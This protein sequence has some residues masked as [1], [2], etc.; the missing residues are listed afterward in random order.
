MAIGVGQHDMSFAQAGEVYVLLT[1]GDGLVAQIPSLLLSTASAIVVTR[2]RGSNENVGQQVSAQLFNDPKALIITAAI[3]GLL[4]IIPGM[5][6]V[7]F[8]FLALVLVGSAYLLINDIK[9]NRK[10]CCKK[11]HKHLSKQ[12]HLKLRS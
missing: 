8:I 9:N 3:M 12:R 6:N 7:V 10:K 4:G 2:V 11:L 1:I 5:P